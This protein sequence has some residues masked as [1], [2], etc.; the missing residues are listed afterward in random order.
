[1]TTDSLRSTRILVTNDDGIHAPGLHALERIA[2]TLSDDV[3]AVAPETEQSAASHSLTTRRPLRVRR[4]GERRFAVDGTPTDCVLVAVNSVL[5]DRKPGLV[6]SGI[7]HGGN[8]A[9]DVGYSGTVAAAMEGALLGI[10]AIAFSQLRK[11]DNPANFE[12]AEHFA[13]GIIE[14]LGQL[15]W[16][17][18]LLFNVNFP[19]LPVEGV[20]GIR[21]GRQGRRDVM[22]GL[23]E[24]QDPAGRPYL[25][26]GDFG[27]D[28]SQEQGTDLAGIREGAITITPLHQNLTH[29]ES[30]AQ[31]SE[32]FGEPGRT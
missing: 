13:P 2:H 20:N 18:D 31:L 30:L 6:L 29:E 14:Q 12:M 1:M 25:W 19:A 10:K 8:L 28:H 24:G 4:F 21:I 17:P 32:V 16:S 11:D 9:E 27:P 23:V 7:N 26:I 22:V 15:S 5:K 3:W